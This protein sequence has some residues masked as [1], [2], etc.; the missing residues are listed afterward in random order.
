MFSRG[1][2]LL[3]SKAAIADRDST[4]PSRKGSYYTIQGLQA[5]SPNGLVKMVNT[6]KQAIEFFPY[7]VAGV[8]FG[9]RRDLLKK[10]RLQCTLN[11]F[12]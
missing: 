6:E 5:P 2:G 11:L 3:E 12:C 8:S 9:F 4:A 7:R 1:T 10:G